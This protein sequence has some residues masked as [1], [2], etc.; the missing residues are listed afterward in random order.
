MPAYNNLDQIKTRRFKILPDASVWLINYCV[1]E[2]SYPDRKSDYKGLWRTLKE[3]KAELVIP[4]QVISEVYNRWMR[5][6]FNHLI[7]TGKLKGEPKDFKSIYRKSE[8]YKLQIQAMNEIFKPYTQQIINSTVKNFDK[9]FT[10]AESIDI[11]DALLL[12]YCKENKD[13]VLFTADADFEFCKHTIT[14][15]THEF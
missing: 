6:H 11:N 13:T 5:L 2:D 14:I 12:Q 7:L 15:L 3:K 1:Y 8:Y 9:I 10:Y 4:F